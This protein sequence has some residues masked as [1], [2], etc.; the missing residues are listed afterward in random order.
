MGDLIERLTVSQKQEAEETTS[1]VT[2]FTITI[3]AS[4]PDK[5]HPGRRIEDCQT[6]KVDTDKDIAQVIKDFKSNSKQAQ[7]GK[8]NLY[9][10]YNNRLYAEWEDLDPSAKNRKQKEGKIGQLGL[11]AMSE[12]ELIS[13]ETEQAVTKNEGVLFTFWSLVPLMIAISLIVAGLGGLFDSRIR[14]AYVLF[15]TIIGIPAFMALVVGITEQFTEQSQVAYTGDAWFGPCCDCCENGCS[16]HS[17]QKEDEEEID[18]VRFFDE[19]ERQ[20]QAS[21][22]DLGLAL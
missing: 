22:L 6:M 13:L 18:L 7:F 1:Q 20:T 11:T 3:R 8:A 12:L 2:N 19:E 21:S 9:L 14:G 4:M 16:T 5:L 10:K 15:G 17:M